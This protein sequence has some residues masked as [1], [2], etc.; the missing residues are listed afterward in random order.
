[1]ILFIWSDSGYHG[2]DG[3]RGLVACMIVQHGRKLYTELTAFLAEQEIHISLHMA[4]VYSVCFNY[5][6]SRAQSCV[7]YASGVLIN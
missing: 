3:E 7:S 4:T 5:R 2:L 1:M 6:F